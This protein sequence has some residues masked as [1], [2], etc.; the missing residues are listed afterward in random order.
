MERREFT[1]GMIASVTS[2]GLMESLFAFNALLPAV[3]PVTKHWAL[4][5]HEYC[6]DLKKQTISVTEWQDQME[7]LYAKIELEELLQFIDF[8]NLQSGFSFPELGVAT[9]HV[10]F[11]KLDGLPEHMVFVKK[12]FGMKKERAIIP[13][14]HSNMSSAH[15]ILKGE[16]HL[17]HYEKLD[18][19]TSHLI[20]KPTI[21]K[22]VSIG[23]SS[24]I[25]DERDNIHWFV[26]S[27]NSAFTFDV[28]MLDLKNNPYAIHNIDIYE[29]EELFDGTMR[30]PILNVETALKKYGKV[31]H[32]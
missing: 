10:K 17:R 29:K 4:Q 22:M 15:L 7:L 14:G 27:T 30:V 21:D 8:K 5:L 28:I 3:L 20:I 31:T 12:I 16:M 18:Q 1:K 24:T 13:H 2:F 9:R 26:A 23:E 6:S 32:H 19:D 11:P 25:S